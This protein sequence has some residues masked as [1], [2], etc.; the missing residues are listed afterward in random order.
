M[1]QTGIILK[2]TSIRPQIHPESTF[3]SDLSAP[4]LS[5]S[6]G[7]SSSG[8]TANSNDET[9]SDEGNG[10]DSGDGLDANADENASVDAAEDTDEGEGGDAGKSGPSVSDEGESQRQGAKGLS[11]EVAERRGS[12]DVF[13]LL[14]SP[15]PLPASPRQAR[16]PTPVPLIPTPDTDDAETDGPGPLPLP[17][18]HPL[19]TMF[20]NDIAGAGGA[21]PFHDVDPVSNDGGG[22]NGFGGD[23]VYMA[24]LVSDSERGHR[25]HGWE[26][27]E[28]GA[29]R[30]SPRRR[31]G[32]RQAR[33]SSSVC[34]RSPMRSR[35]SPRS[36]RS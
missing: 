10:G 32:K 18:P 20:G 1:E 36:G 29:C 33:V 17:P 7:V 15:D 34:A 5:L 25:L 11:I 14:D 27:P 12:G 22:E 13:D 3:P 19:P 2:L 9:G 31:A 16:P 26:G 4:F 28:R 23:G 21:N 30:H 24:E 8:S 6:F 35:S